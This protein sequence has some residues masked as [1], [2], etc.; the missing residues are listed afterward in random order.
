MASS[1]FSLSPFSSSPRPSPPPLHN[2]HNH[3][4]STINLAASTSTLIRCASSSPSTT[5]SSSSSSYRKSAEQKK[6]HWKV[7]EYPG[8][9]DSSHNSTRRFGNG[10]GRPPKTPIKNIKKKLDRKNEAK[11]WANTVTEALSHLIHTKQWLQALEVPY[12]FL[13]YIHT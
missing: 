12:E 13:T 10:N 5:K 9:S 1:S 2:L 3:H 11:A 7:G 8:I 4:H 6:R